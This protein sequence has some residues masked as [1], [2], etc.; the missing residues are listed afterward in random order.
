MLIKSEK[1]FL[2]FL[3]Q[4]EKICFN[5]DSY[6]KTMVNIREDLK[7]GEK[8]IFSSGFG[9]QPFDHIKFVG[10]F[11]SK[12]MGEFLSDIDVAEIV[13]YN[14][15]F[16]ERWK[17]IME[18]IDNSPIIFMRFYCGEDEELIPP[19]KIDGRGS[20][21]FSLKETER[22]LE[23]TIKNIYLP[24]YLKIFLK[25][26][27]DKSSLSIRDLLDIEEEMKKYNTIAWGK[28]D[29]I[30]GNVFFHGKNYNLLDSLLNYNKKKTI[31]YVYKFDDDALL[32]DYS[33][34]EASKEKQI[35]IGS[36]E[37]RAFYFDDPIKIIKMFKRWIWPKYNEL[38]ADILDKTTRKYTTIA[39]RL[40]MII[41][42]RKYKL[43]SENKLKFLENDLNNY[44]SKKDT[45]YHQ[46][47]INSDNIEKIYEKI[48]ELLKNEAYQGVQNMKDAN[49]LHF[50]NF[51][52]IAIYEMRAIEA[53]L[54]I[55]K[56]I[57]QDRIDRNFECPFFQIDL[58][59]LK[60]IYF[61]AVNSNIE[62]KK[63]LICLYKICLDKNID[64]RLVAETIFTNNNFKI[65][66]ANNPNY[67]NLFD[68]NT[69]QKIANFHKR[70]LPYYQRSVIFAPILEFDSNLKNFSRNLKKLS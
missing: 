31:R 42:I 28:N 14:Q 46:F 12:K 15:N 63:L 48:L 67:Y 65:K 32:V 6:K 40:D 5:L 50:S 52:L 27:L 21:L 18:N 38:Y 66:I 44:L 25:K 33:L 68:N 4:L 62:P 29:I 43:L 55:S 23:K 69:K 16:I 54:Q 9:K 1:I 7:K 41:R 19:W 2:D 49:M 51:L 17:F 35:E 56:S 26:Y 37:V 60:K 3:D 8:K 57:I 10:S 70:D 39:F 13:E 53:Q 58:K 24:D 11:F 59:T 47:F 36:L 20:C 34:R 30:N 22:W 64:M 61:H 45:Y